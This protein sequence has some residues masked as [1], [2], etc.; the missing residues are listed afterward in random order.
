[1]CSKIEENIEDQHP[2]YRDLIGDTSPTAG[3]ILWNFTK[4]LVGRDGY[5]IKRFGTLV[6][7]KSKKIVNEVEK[8]LDQV[9]I[10][11]M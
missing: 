10:P 11:Q 6:S 4:I 9:Y 3:N 1:M 5:P 2:I 8:A 7:P